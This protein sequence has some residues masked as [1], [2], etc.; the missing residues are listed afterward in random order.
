M[1]LLSDN[2]SR[3]YYTFNPK[4]VF[5]VTGMELADMDMTEWYDKLVE[6][7]SIKKTQRD[8]LRVVQE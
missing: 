6:N 3:Y 8:K 1:N 5:D 7:R 4:N 2:S